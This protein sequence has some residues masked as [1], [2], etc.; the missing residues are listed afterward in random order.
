MRNW[1]VARDALSEAMTPERAT[2]SPALL[3]RRARVHLELRELEQA[4]GDSGKASG[5]RVGV[6]LLA[7]A[8][9]FDCLAHPAS[10]I[11]HQAGLKRCVCVCLTRPRPSPAR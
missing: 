6:A 1:A 10:P 5:L 2:A 3:L 4:M 8:A 9:Y 11:G 7:S